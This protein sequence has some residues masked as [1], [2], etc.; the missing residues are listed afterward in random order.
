MP[1]WFNA[2]DFSEDEAEDLLEEM[3]DAL[4]AMQRFGYNFP[5]TAIHSRDAGYCS[6]DQLIQEENDEEDDF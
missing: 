4:D 3:E 2:A 5:Q 6:E 1:I